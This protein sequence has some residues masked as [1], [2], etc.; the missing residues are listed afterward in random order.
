MRRSPPR[1]AGRK[2]SSS[3][4][5]TSCNRCRSSVLSITVTGLWRFSGPT[6]RRRMRRD[7]RDLHL[8]GLEHTFSVFQSLRTVPNGADR[9][10]ADV[11]SLTVAPVLAARSPA[12]DPSLSG[13]DDVGF[14]RMVFV[15]ASEAIT[16]AG[17]SILLPVSA[18]TSPP[19]LRDATSERSAGPSS[20]CLSDPS[21]RSAA[22]S[23]AHRLVAQVSGRSLCRR[24]QCSSVVLIVL[25]RARLFDLVQT[26]LLAI[27]RADRQR[28]CRADRAARAGS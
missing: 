4:C 14:R 1:A 12:R 13:H 23:P 24:R 7:L 9:G 2:K 28:Y 6:A 19:R 18:P 15:V 16:V 5:S 27:N 8:P 21:I 25:Q 10:G 22:V 3:R 17:Q 20:S 11:P 26:G